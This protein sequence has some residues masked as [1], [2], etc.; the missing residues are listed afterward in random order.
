MHLCCFLFS[1]LELDLINTLDLPTRFSSKYLFLV[2][3][4][5]LPCLYSNQ[6][7]PRQ[8]EVLPLQDRLGSMIFCRRLLSLIE[9]WLIKF[10]QLE[11]FW[12]SFQSPNSLALEKSLKGYCENERDRSLSIS[13]DS[14]TGTR[15][16]QSHKWGLS[17]L[18]GEFRKWR[19]SI[20]LGLPCKSWEKS[21]KISQYNNTLVRICCV[22]G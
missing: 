11:N 8:I 10:S 20:S 3:L 16:K 15:L 18:K 14:R 22:L 19:I 9:M 5:S 17:K 21:S 4:G 12:S 1:V 7:L 6:K 2:S 13:T